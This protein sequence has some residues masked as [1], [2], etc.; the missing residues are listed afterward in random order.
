MT[1]FVWT[2]ASVRFVRSQ[3]GQ[4]R[5]VGEVEYHH[6]MSSNMSISLVL[7]EYTLIL[8]V[9]RHFPLK[10]RSLF[11]ICIEPK[12]PSAPQWGGDRESFS[13]LSHSRLQLHGGLC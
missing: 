11:V 8:Q 5:K 6:S 2:K 10:S 13:A 12:P 3:V 7:T 1:N 9:L 4:Q